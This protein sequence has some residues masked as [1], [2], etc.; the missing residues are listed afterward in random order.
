MPYDATGKWRPY[1]VDEIRKVHPEWFPEYSQ[2]GYSQ[3]PRA[4]DPQPKTFG[5]S[6]VPRR[7]DPGQQPKTFGYSQVPRPE[8]KSWES[9][10]PPVLYGN[11]TAARN[12]P[13]GLQGR[14]FV[15]TTGA[16]E[17][18]LSALLD[19]D[20]R[21]EV[22]SYAAGGLHKSYEGPY[23]EKI[24][25]DTTKKITSMDHLGAPLRAI[26]DANR[27]GTE[28]AEHISPEFAG[29]ADFVGQVLGL[30]PG[31]V[32]S[33][34]TVG[35]A[36]GKLAGKLLKALPDNWF[37]KTAKSTAQGV[38]T[39]AGLFTAKE[40]IQELGAPEEQTFLG[41][42][43]DVGV[44]SAYF[45][46]YGASMPTVSNVMKK[47]FDTLPP[48]AKA[49]L[50]A[51]TKKAPITA[52]VAAGTV[53]G[54]ISGA[55]VGTGIG[56]GKAIIN[57]DTTIM[58]EL[59]N[60]A[61]GEA[62]E[63]FIQG[64]AYGVARRFSRLLN[65]QRIEGEATTPE[66]VTAQRI[67]KIGNLAPEDI[68]VAVSERLIT[69][70]PSDIRD[71]FEIAVQD[72]MSDGLSE[73]E[74]RSEALLYLSETPEGQ[75]LAAK[76][77]AD[78]Y[79]SKLTEMQAEGGVPVDLEVL[80]EQAAQA[81]KAQ[82]TAEEL[83][84][85]AA[86]E[87][88]LYR[89]GKL[90]DQML[91]AK[92]Y[93]GQEREARRQVDPY[94]T[95]ISYNPL[96]RPEPEVQ[97]NPWKSDLAQGPRELFKKDDLVRI[98]GKKGIYQV[99]GELAGKK[100]K[101]FGPEGEISFRPQAY[102]K[103]EGYT[104]GD[105]VTSSKRE[106]VFTVQDVRDGKR[107]RV[108]NEQGQP[109]HFSD[110][111][112]SPSIGSAKPAISQ[113][114][115]EPKKADLK[116]MLDAEL[117]DI[118]ENMTD[119]EITAK[120][121][122]TGASG[123]AETAA[124]EL[125]SRIRPYA[126]KDA[127]GRPKAEVTPKGGYQFDADNFGA[128]LDRFKKENPAPDQRVTKRVEATG[129][130]VTFTEETTNAGYHRFLIQNEDG[131]RT[132]I[133]ETE[134]NGRPGLYTIFKQAN[135]SKSEDRSGIAK[136][137]PVYRMNRDE[138]RNALEG[139][140]YTH[141][142]SNPEYD[143]WLEN[144]PE[145][146]RE[147]AMLDWMINTGKFNPT[148]VYNG[149]PV[150]IM[151][152]GDNQYAYK[153][154]VPKEGRRSHPGGTTD[155]SN[156]TPIKLPSD[157]MEASTEANKEMEASTEVN[158]EMEAS[159]EVSTEM[160]ASTEVKQIM[161]LNAAK[162]GVEL[163]FPKKPD[164]AIL[165]RLRDAGF[166]YNNKNKADVYWWAVQKP[167]TLELARELS[168]EAAT[169]V[170]SDKPGEKEVSTEVNKQYTGTKRISKTETVDNNLSQ[171]VVIE[172]GKVTV[173]SKVKNLDHELLPRGFDADSPKMLSYSFDLEAWKKL[174]E[175]HANPH[176]ARKKFIEKQIN[177]E[178]V[179]EKHDNHPVINRIVDA[180]IRAILKAVAE[181]EIKPGFETGN[182]ITVE[183][184]EASTEAS[185][186]MEASTEASTEMEASTEV[187]MFPVAGVNKDKIVIPPIDYKDNPD[188]FQHAL[189]ELPAVAAYDSMQ[190]TTI[191]DLI[192]SVQHEID[193][194]NEQ[195]DDVL[196]HMSRSEMSKLKAELGRYIKR[197]KENVHLAKLHAPG[198]AASDK[199]KADIQQDHP[200][201]VGL[202][203]VPGIS[204]R[205][206][207][208]KNSKD[209]LNRM[210]WKDTP[211]K[212][213]GGD[214]EIHKVYWSEEFGI[215]GQTY[216]YA[217]RDAEDN[218]GVVKANW[219]SLPY[220]TQ[221]DTE[222]QDRQ[223]DQ[224]Q[225]EDEDYNLPSGAVKLETLEVGTVVIP[226]GINSGQV[227]RIGD[228]T[229]N[230]YEKKLILINLHIT[231]GYKQK[232]IVERLKY[233]PTGYVAYR[234]N[235]SKPVSEMTKRQVIGE[236]VDHFIKK[237]ELAPELN[238]NRHVA[239]EAFKRAANGYAVYTDG[240]IIVADKG[241]ITFYK[242][243][244]VLEEKIS[245]IRDLLREFYYKEDIG[246]SVVKPDK[247]KAEQ[248]QVDFRPKKG[249]W[250]EEQRL[251]VE[252]KMNEGQKIGILVH[253]IHQ[254]PQTKELIVT[255]VVRPP[256]T[257]GLISSQTKIETDGK[258]QHISFDNTIG[259][260]W[261][262]VYRSKVVQQLLEMEKQEGNNTSDAEEQIQQPTSKSS[263][264]ADLKQGGKAKDNPKW[265]Q[266][267]EEEA[268]ARIDSRKGRLMSGLPMDDMV[269]YSIIGF[270]KMVRGT[271]DF[272]KWSKE[273]L[274]EFGDSIRLFLGGIYGQSQAMMD[275]SEDDLEEMI[276]LSSKE[277]KIDDSQS[278]GGKDSE[279]MEGEQSQ[280]VS[281]SVDD[282]SDTPSPNGIGGTTRGAGNR[283]VGGKSST[284]RTRKKGTGAS[285]DQ[286]NGDGDSDGGRTGT[287]SGTRTGGIKSPDFVITD[288]L[289]ELGGPRTKFKQ[290]IAAIRLLR[291]LQSEGR[292][293]TPEEQRA[294]ARYVGWG[295]LSQAFDDR[296]EDWKNEYEEMQR[297]IADGVIDEM[298]YAA[299][300]AS[301]L[302]AHYTSAQV[303]TEMYEG[304]RR[305]GF[306][307]GRILE[308]AMGTGNF[309]GLMPKDM[310]K[311]SERTGVEKDS[312][313]GGI[314]TKLYPQTNIH[315]KPFEKFVISD[316]YFD[317][318]IGNVPFGNITITDTNY[319]KH[320]TK[321]IHNYFFVKTLDKV[322]DGG[323]VMFITSSGTLNAPTNVSIRDEIAKRADFLGAI[324]LPSSAFKANA[325]TEVTADILILQKR[326]QGQEAKHAAN[327]LQT[328]SVNVDGEALPDNN[329]FIQHPEMVL[330]AYMDD[331]IHPGRIGVKDDGRNLAEA[332]SQA[333]KRLPE[334]VYAGRE[335][336]PDEFTN[337]QEQQAITNGWKD[338]D[339]GAYYIENGKL[340]KRVGD[341][342][343][344]SK[345]T[346]TPL[347]RI[348]GMVPIRDSVRKLLS[349]MRN[350]DITDEQIK[351]QQK[352]L[353]KMY[354]AFK[355][356]FGPLNNLA[357]TR[358]MTDDPVGSGLL[359]SIEHYEKEG[360]VEK[361]SKGDLFT[362]RTLSPIRPKDKADTAEEAL[363]LSLSQKGRLDLAFMSQLTGKDEQTLVA[364]LGERVYLDPTS[365]Q[366]VIEDEYLSGNVREKL[367]KAEAASYER[368]AAALKTVLPK[369]LESHQ[370]KV[371]IGAQWIP[372]E[373]YEDF[374][375]EVLGTEDKI[376]VS[377]DRLTNKWAV[378]ELRGAPN[379]SSNVIN[380]R[381]FGIATTQGRNYDMV[382]IMEDT[383]NLQPAVVKKKVAVGDDVKW[384]IDE[385]LTA[386]A[387][388]IQKQLQTMF[389][390][391]LWSDSDRKE[392]LLEFYNW[393]Y[394]NHRL[395]T[396]DGSLVYGDDENSV[397]IPGFNNVVFKMRSHQKDAVWRILQGTNTLLAHVVGAGKTM[398]MIV[399]AMEMK[400][401]GLANK[402]TIVVPNKLVGQWYGDIF[403][404]YPG[405]RV[406]KLTSDDIPSV[407]PRK[408]KGEMN[409]EYAKKQAKNRTGR[410]KIL[411]KIAT[412]DYD[413]ILMSHNLFGRLPVS[414]ERQ[415]VYI[416]E[417]IEEVREAMRNT[418]DKK[419][420]KELEK[421]L[422]KL[423]GG[424]NDRIDEDR[425]DIVIPFEELGIDQIFVDEA[426]KFKN[427]KFHSNISNVAGLSFKAS[428]RAEDMYLK[429]GYLT[430]LRNGGGVVF[431]T[432][433]PIANTMGEMFNLQ[434]YLKKDSLD[435][436]GISHFDAWAAMFAETVTDFEMTA[437]GQFKERTRFSYFHN[438]GELLRL[439]FVFADVKTATM[440]NLPKP[441]NV[442]HESIIVELSKGQRAYMRELVNR[443]ENM[444]YV[445]KSE[446]NFL[447]L[448]TDGKK[449]AVDL[450]LVDPTAEDDPNS[451]LNTAVR[452]IVKVYKDETYANTI[453]KNSKE[454]IKDHAQL[455]F[456]D[457]GTPKKKKE[458][459]KDDDDD[460][461]NIKAKT[462]EE[463]L[464]LKRLQAEEATFKQLYQDIK[465]KLMKQ[466]IPEHE[467][468][469][470]HDAKTEVQE[471]KLYK[472]VND[473]KIRV[474]IG[475]TEKMGAGVNVQ[476]RLVALHH[477]DPTWR[478][479]DIEQREGRIIRQ[480]NEFDDVMVYSYVTQGSFDG[481]MWDLLR[482]K[483]QFIEQMMN[484]NLDMRS[485]EDVGA[486]SFG[487][488]EVASAALGTNVMK[489]K[490]QVERKIADLNAEKAKFQSNRMAAEKDIRDT[491]DRIKG[492]EKQIKQIN[493]DITQTHDYRGDKFSVTITG[494]VY[495]NREEAGN[496][497]IELN[498][499]E[500][501]EEHYPQLEQM[502]S[503]AEVGQFGKFKLFIIHPRWNERFML[504]GPSGLEYLFSTTGTAEGSAGQ[505]GRV[506]ASFSE[507]IAHAEE[508]IQ[509][510]T[511]RIEDSKI[512][513]TKTFDKDDELAGLTRRLAEIRAEIE[514]LNAQYS[515]ASGEV[516]NEDGD[517]DVGTGT[518]GF[519]ESSQRKGTYGFAEPARKTAAPPK[520]KQIEGQEK[521]ET[522]REH[523]DAISR[524]IEESKRVLTP[525][526]TKKL[527]DLLAEHLETVIDKD[528][529]GQRRAGQFDYTH[530]IGRVKSKHYGN[531]R[532]MGHE[533]G[534]AY[535][536]HL[537]IVGVDEELRAMYMALYPNARETFGAKDQRI[538]GFAEFFQQWV[539]DP[540]QTAKNVP[541]TTEMFE[542]TILKDKKLMPLFAKIRTIVDQDFGDDA[543]GRTVASVIVPTITTE[544]ESMTGANYAVGAARRA[545]FE[546]ADA[547]IPAR[548]MATAAKA[549]GYEQDP[550]Y[551][552]KLLSIMDGG[553]TKAV[554]AFEAPARDQDG[555]FLAVQSLKSLYQNIVTEIDNVT[556]GG[557]VELQTVNWEV[558]VLNKTIYKQYKK[559]GSMQIAGAI[560]V[561]Q[562]VKERYSRGYTTLPMTKQ[563]ADEVLEIAKD[564]F[565]KAVQAATEFTDVFSSV[566]LDKLQ[567]A[568][569]LNASDRANIEAGSDSYIP[570]IYDEAKATFLSGQDKGGQTYNQVVK[571]FN[572]KFMPVLDPLQ[573]VMFKLAQVEQ[574]I[575]FK[576]S[577]DEIQSLAMHKDMG[578]FASIVPN[579]VKAQYV[580]ISRTLDGVKQL[581]GLKED[582]QIGKEMTI[583]SKV[584]AGEH[585]K[586][587]IPQGTD[588]LKNE[589]I[590]LNYN[591][592][593]PVAIKVAPDV[594]KMV[595]AMSPIQINK[596]MKTLAYTSRLF[597]FTA[598][599]TPTYLKNAVSRDVVIGALQSKNNVGALAAHS[600]KTI[601][602]MAGAYLNHR[603]M[604]QNEWTTYMEQQYQLFQSSGGSTSA[605]ENMLRGMTMNTRK[606]YDVNRMH[607][608]APG[609][610]YAVGRSGKRTLYRS[611]HSPA[612][613]LRFIEEAPRLTEFVSTL[614]KEFKD[615]GYDPDE[616]YEKFAKE[617]TDALPDDLQKK[618]ERII[619]DATY[620][621][622]EITTNFRVHGANQVVRSYVP[623]VTFLHGTMQGTMR[624]ARQVKQHPWKTLG[625]ALTVIGGVSALSWALMNA[626]D[627]DRRWLQDLPSEMRDR[628]W[629]F[630][631]FAVPGTYITIAKPFDY[632]ILANWGE[633]F[634]D[635]HL[636]EEV[637]RRGRADD[638]FSLFSTIFKT[639]LVSNTFI[640]IAQMWGNKNDFGNEIVP[641]SDIY[642]KEGW[643]RSAENTSLTSRK[644]AEFW[645]GL[646]FVD[647]GF[648]PR[649][650]DHFIK[651]M[652]GR[653]GS[654]ALSVGDQIGG[655]H[656]P[657]A[658]AEY[659]FLY[660]TMVYGQ[661]EGGSSR[662]VN[663]FYDDYTG[664][665]EMLGTIKGLMEAERFDAAR[666]YVTAENIQ[667]IQLYPAMEHIADSIRESNKQFD[668]IIQSKEANPEE[669]HRA[670]L[671]RNYVRRLS[672]GLLYGQAPPLP[673]NIGLTE[674]HIEAIMAE[675]LS[676]AQEKMIREAK[677]K[678]GPSS[679][680]QALNELMQ[681]QQ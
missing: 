221:K 79:Q 350:P 81:S 497:L 21:K 464:A 234:W 392:R 369:D 163:R 15:K 296:K 531:W 202:G 527:A 484:G 273:M 628:Y 206:V 629:W 573:A 236:F 477:I 142:E 44:G 590:L 242:N 351:Q 149:Q 145:L 520:R 587:F 322:R 612:D 455:V 232:N 87:E 239:I 153:L 184:M 102:R 449:M 556:N 203:Y 397:L 515:N 595:Q 223:E 328:G 548:D 210:V 14:P 593:E 342:G 642:N 295:G 652:F 313:T 481:L 80:P 33:G 421:M 13:Y 594:M 317:A 607:T 18:L 31:T 402:P 320:V 311:G 57:E 550:E 547:L 76:A 38:G 195:P 370:I 42:A 92:G 529:V 680:L 16:E 553:L 20:K 175:S 460:V 475:S 660:G 551:L 111:E 588:I 462:P 463:A 417:Q 633:R 51:L 644:I 483:A 540:E 398:E 114:P 618:M 390:E 167:K 457:L 570:F 401:L 288:E 213:N 424:I 658:G 107:I 405:A 292:N 567:R 69:D 243:G 396:F 391:W 667:K 584:L 647:G 25:D 104:A 634:L 155:K 671:L 109:F 412:G 447:K 352:Q 119:E 127:S 430:E 168:G 301:S 131:S 357:N 371:R 598:L 549:T 458:S 83:M 578:K 384:V 68:G 227:Y 429:T 388:N 510:L 564:R 378:D 304:L 453:G 282:G 411:S 222:V 545:I 325:G 480:G 557:K 308:P 266:K 340:M 291:Q 375:N 169:P 60:E 648:S 306:K 474:L 368:N 229:T 344:L 241:Q 293:A 75:A 490:G 443:A 664:T 260:T 191:D 399:A 9:A 23:L 159:T 441:K 448:T 244:S 110:N 638:M 407:S 327:F 56:V 580:N 524:M 454:P 508:T 499:K 101:V 130:P 281:E 66:A 579:G 485:V 654:Y 619:V 274:D 530:N 208:E 561:A 416:H 372:N 500:Y 514:Q 335:M 116:L 504:K 179:N 285:M 11:W 34:L 466:G 261:D 133:T 6:Q 172:D 263:S 505:L 473:G 366:Y 656:R 258:S 471:K 196:G 158:T 337:K 41:H 45:G 353:D 562:R 600:A 309:F 59:I 676:G 348:M 437:S 507:K 108:V 627:D 247:K 419:T 12:Q 494:T 446:D 560:M 681:Q 542:A 576:R 176:Y 151:P 623:T 26:Q 569:I 240:L 329:Y 431:A 668:E 389:E 672:S 113:Q 410:A 215:E 659:G 636:S 28:G 655:K 185:T 617:G 218:M 565:P 84:N 373:D 267:M 73:V 120:Y 665:R 78:F 346:G 105:T 118:T 336:T 669:R 136:T 509:T 404:Q 122:V 386:Q 123:F 96:Y 140:A 436:L 125:D 47:S 501:R 186:E 307:G 645:A 616:M 476:K 188:Q 62:S 2:K 482:I 128:E 271:V 535:D 641:A 48:T 132:V 674:T 200:D 526:T 284:K 194:I 506:F 651:G 326:P 199:I 502:G 339:D 394:N 491:P 568:G 426:H 630:P 381:E 503:S 71:E 36:G 478:P 606:R 161:T 678:G 334:N 249:E 582:S 250:T 8:A 367:K 117:K 442:K 225:D 563:M 423:R 414:P 265:L 39:G 270:S 37:T 144:H 347:H 246:G 488:A 657:K 324:R 224:E 255:D 86:Y 27:K 459:D 106:G 286:E 277:E 589:L 65:P 427:L 420:I 91:D 566:V 452:N 635:W 438:V 269:D 395:R 358:L 165:Q 211:F 574:A 355:K 333:F 575:E 413:I 586:L 409:E 512:L 180:Q 663:K 536:K 287:D 650:V 611:L 451:K 310:T 121:G 205:V 156:F 245:N 555:K 597:R 157:E 465:D 539:L 94:E 321:A 174:E 190:H 592:G 559:M 237:F 615:R 450:R 98:P 147:H 228:T 148:H 519:I 230:E 303:V 523:I 3:V 558:K 5:Y 428:K 632:A 22:A 422:E 349:S 376:R 268:R 323:I 521:K 496:R 621:S 198:Y 637:N 624:T 290:N 259:Q 10:T 470:I 610:F 440:L 316:G 469:F 604:D 662:T 64:I 100:Q 362:K 85:R 472:A 591:N 137:I 162:N 154:P 305:L 631:N 74:A 209:Y 49:A 543:M 552:V 297:L 112:L 522:V 365:E 639:D 537:G 439:F 135:G 298:E 643:M 387:K 341:R 383:L 187:N 382:D 192:L 278:D 468:G 7:D 605:A 129:K 235:P 312:V 625:Y 294:L 257:T 670:T 492:W 554:A 400:R 679:I 314:A 238:G 489:E 279:N 609:W 345:L 46:A 115:A 50:V 538:E 17:S 461:E 201:A 444:K 189:K 256:G 4:D 534:H 97:T 183:E 541:K 275:M 182:S 363:I 173:T 299:M 331:K 415:Q 602:I 425:K 418:E 356:Q 467:I 197:W 601:G 262:E 29:A 19:K 300:R 653:Y 181:V 43:K 343:E 528:F 143:R 160:E 577:I 608:K 673:P 379:L 35:K 364:E 479:A 226:F 445:D 596:A 487:F 70:L 435:D 251:A 661:A 677:T 253:M 178:Q 354:D 54:A 134:Q 216:G 377:H 164:D 24:F 219:V 55:M 517:D 583:M 264:S 498:E 166:R 252:K 571:K 338:V 89:S 276:R 315:V 640:T 393:T 546:A 525:S 32:A 374:M 330:G 95:L 434:R 93:T 318:A 138:I 361:S 67:E 649:M 319:P 385:E 456:L 603:G 533:I 1:S 124:Y 403:E 204:D 150:E 408:T 88:H 572:A 52:S 513:L 280:D 332:I 622:G 283:T 58:E 359:F 581:L 40:T 486:L 613:M 141:S 518:Y 61:K 193:L 544:E 146:N 493:H 406:L 433:T 585:L 516:E 254:N 212:A 63:N 90:K 675:V 207:V 646:P 214:R 666:K 360:S 620:N 170:E 614:K 99:Q 139:K 511:K 217:W 53:E 82:P 495:T 626:D 233:N 103:F 171:T 177:L 220:D 30:I 231:D 248:E 289:D 380:T 77:A 599:A 272:A 532:V 302:N 126:H 72:L 152:Y 432:G